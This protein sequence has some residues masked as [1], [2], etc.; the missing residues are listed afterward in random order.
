[1]TAVQIYQEAIQRVPA[2][3]AFLID[4]L[5]H[6]PSVATMEE[7]AQL[8]LM[9]K[10]DYILAHPTEDLCMDGSPHCAHLWLRSSGTSK[11]PFF[12]PRRAEDETGLPQALSR[13]FQAYTT[14]QAQPTLIVVGL[15]LGP[16]GTGMQSSFAFRMLARQVPGLAV[17]S[18]GLQNDSI[19]EVLERLSPHYRR[20][21]LF[22]YPPFAKMVL[23][24]AVQRGMDLASRNI[25]LMVGGE[26]I[27]EAYRER[28]W[29]LLGHTEKNL[30]SVW[31]LYGSTDFANVGFENP[32]TIAARRLMVQHDLFSDALGEPDIPMLFQRVPAQTY[33]E[34]VDGELVVSRLQGIPLVRYRS[35]DRVRIIPRA[36]LLERLRQLG[37]DA[38]QM[39]RDAGLEVPEW[40][41]PFVALYGRIDQ[42]LFFYG[43]KISIEQIKTALDAPAMAPYYNG[44]FL[45]RCVE[46]DH[47]YPQVEIAL[48]DSEVLR[49]ADL[50][51][52][53]NL[54]A[55]ELEKTQSEFRE[56]RTLAP[57]KPHLRLTLTDKSAFELGWKTRRM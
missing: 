56:I 13:L 5:G 41:T 55:H 33:F 8:P 46:S 42:T 26:G 10:A 18:P 6:V 54:L 1:M 39:V 57:E 34:V 12:W 28:M 9:S 37:H 11:K 48:E 30:D 40:E 21:L 53:T 47:G 43:A 19:L 23:E 16:W 52:V 4:R 49:S 24:E 32:L 3:R 50:Q 36:E 44:R 35:G 7:F 22:S 45:A 17:V 51:A 38:E 14:P 31:S 27:S 29:D 20:T 25:H 15:A 2:Y